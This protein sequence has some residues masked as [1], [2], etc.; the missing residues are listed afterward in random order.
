M[1]PLSV[2]HILVREEDQANVWH[3]VDQVGGQSLVKP[4]GPL[5]PH[6]PVDAIPGA[7][8]PTL[9]VLQAGSHHLVGVG[10]Q[11]RQQLGDCGECEIE[12]RRDRRVDRL[13]QARI[14]LLINSHPVT[15]L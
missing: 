5:K 10:R 2:D 12:G 9:S 3:H 6:N 8:V 11:G 15:L 4:P 14:I 13:Q 7:G 1:V